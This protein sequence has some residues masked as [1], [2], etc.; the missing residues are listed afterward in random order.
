MIYHIYWG[1]S[2]NAGLY[3]DE[4][5]QV[6]AKEG[7]KQKVFVSFF[8][9]FDYGEK[10]F[11]HRSDIAHSQYKSRGR[12][13]VQAYEIIVSLLKILI[14]SAKDKPNVVNYSL[15][16][17]SWAFLVVFLK[18][19]KKISK[20]KLIVTCHDV[21][22]FGHDIN[23]NDS[24]IRNRKKIIEL[25]DFLLVHNENST[26]DLKQYFGVGNDRIV[27]HP[28]PV[29][30]LSKLYKPRVNEKKYDFLF[31]GG[32]R[33]EKGINFL[34]DS[35]PYVIQ[36]N[37]TASLCIAGLK[38][39]CDDFDEESLSKQNV[40]FHLH[41]IS[42]QDFVD[43]IESSRYVLLPYLRGT[44]SGI[45]STVLS[46]HAKVITSDIPMYK[47]N[48]MLSEKDMFEVGNRI[49]FVS[50][51]TK[52]LREYDENKSDFLLSEY[53][54]IFNKDVLNAYKRV[55]DS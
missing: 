1:T 6:L 44:N 51:V 36:A 34:L 35:W 11:F 2:G 42:D 20:A 7:Y 43:Y 21:C 22:P 30:D 54:S 16:S 31:I 27:S 29:M 8:Y 10:I 26:N 52:K 39:T 19:L 49:S 32:L 38:D 41:Y 48:P 50:F 3:L 45:I 15:A 17:G 25:A 53:R 24:E 5:Y 33:K 14:A 9:P 28:F 13:I 4:I 47:N 46:L 18:M 55:Y 12:K 40:E 37:P 23:S